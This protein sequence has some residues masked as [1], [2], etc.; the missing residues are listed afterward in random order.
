MGHALKEAQA[1][2]DILAPAHALTNSH[3]YTRFYHGRPLW[4]EILR[5]LNI[6]QALLVQVGKERANGRGE[7]VTGVKFSHVRLDGGAAHGADAAPRAQPRLEANAA[8]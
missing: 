3:P 1:P 6:A 5:V 4:W 7:R 8:E 2:T